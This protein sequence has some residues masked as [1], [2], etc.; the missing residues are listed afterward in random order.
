MEKHFNFGDVEGVWWSYLVR[1]DNLKQEG[2][3][4]IFGAQR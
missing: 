1:E 3:Q 2:Y 4:R